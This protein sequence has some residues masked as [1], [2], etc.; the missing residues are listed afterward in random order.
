MIA[1]FKYLKVCH[2]EGKEIVP[3]VPNE[4]KFQGNRFQLDIKKNEPGWP[5]RW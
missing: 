1:I 2:A 3:F 5:R 4:F